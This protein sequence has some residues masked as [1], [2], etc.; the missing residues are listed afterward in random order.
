MNTEAH[1]VDEDDRE[2][3]NNLLEV[4]SAERKLWALIHSKGLLRI[5]VQELYH[6]ARS[7][8]ED[9]IINDREGMELQDVEYCLWKLH[10]KH[11]DEFRKRIR[12]SSGSAENKKI[13][14]SQNVASLQN[15]IEDHVEG[16]KTFLSDASLFYKD[17]IRKMRESC[18]LSEELLLSSKDYSSFSV[19]PAN[20]LKCQY[21]CHRFL[22]CLGDLA[23]Y[24]E[25]CQK[26]ENRNCKW[27]V[28]A[29]YYFE[30][31]TVYPDSGNPHNQLALLATYVADEFLALYHCVRSLA[32]K[33]PFPDAWDNLM[34]LFEKNKSSPVH[35]LSSEIQYDISRP[36]ERCFLRTKSQ[37]SSVSSNKKLEVTELASSGI[38]DLWPL[39][40]RM[41]SFFFVK[42]RLEDFHCAFSSTLRKLE[43]VLALKETELKVSLESYGRL[44]AARSGPYRAI[45]LVSILII[46]I[47][48][49]PEITKVNTS[50]DKNETEQSAFSKLAWTTTF[51]F[52]GRVI[53]RCLEDMNGD[54]CPLLF[55]VLVFVEWL[56]GVLDKAELYSAH[57]NVKNAAAYFFGVFCSLLNHLDNKEGEVKFLDRNAFWEDYEL[58][59]FSPVA[60]AHMQLD[61]STQGEQIR[62]YDNGYTSRAHRILHAAMRIVEVSKTTRKWLSYDKVG[63]KFNAAEMIQSFD[64]REAEEMKVSHAKEL[65]HD[66]LYEKE[67]SE[68]NQDKPSVK[69][70]NASVDDEEVILFNPITRHNSEPIHSLLMSKGQ[71]SLHEKDDQTASSD[72]VLR[73]AT[74]LLLPQNQGQLESPKLYSGT[75]DFRFSKPYSQPE[76]TVIDSS[77]YPAGPPSLSGWV[78]NRESM[79]ADSDKGPKALHRHD[80]DPIAEMPSASLGGLSVNEKE[81]SPTTYNP[82]PLYVAPLPSAPQLP[83]DANW[84][85]GHSSNFQESKTGA[86]IREAEGILG[87]TPTTR[88]PNL[89]PTHGPFSPRLANFIDGYPPL[90]G[91][92]SSEWLYQYRNSHIVEQANDRIWPV[93]VNAPGDF[94]NFYS[95]DASRFDFFDR[96]GNPLPSSPMVYLDNPHLNT[97]L[98]LYGVEEQRREKL[99]HGYQRPISYGCVTAT[100]LGAEKPP[101]LQYL[102]EREWQLQRENKLRGPPYMGN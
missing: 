94:G 71:M 5:D 83:A 101:L 37:E 53:E 29:N 93:Q 20:L 24:K 95:H 46:I 10:Y 6:K 51:I 81:F 40:V 13:G 60:H 72:E 22:V 88:Y 43:A 2:K 61:F 87:P 32:I 52:M 8:Y 31:A 68:E 25:L 28:A 18:G 76:Q 63:R 86:K 90:L 47:H 17:M 66:E 11:I 75:T 4:V 49:L 102:Q 62:N 82:S 16:F 54:S 64:R 38:N 50:V 92:S 79:H 96:W 85:K 39:F 35:S 58:R 14:T 42:S 36:S 65:K 45:Q 69:N 3:E 44:D 9:M 26:S 70:E 67:I 89:S 98:P 12:H 100:D 7:G 59:G 78:F 56:V 33:E 1:A 84:L 41:I 80:L 74:S 57:E 55:T 99:F 77:A 21:A 19:V 30:A 15:N 23:R 34:L 73:R 27:S 48:N 91:M 97:N